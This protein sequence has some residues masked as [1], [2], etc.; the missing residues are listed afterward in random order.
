MKAAGQAVAAS[1]DG[2][3]SVLSKWPIRNEGTSYTSM[4]NPKTFEMDSYDVYYS[5][6]TLEQ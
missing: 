5:N 2:L 3:Y 6:N 1:M 4:M